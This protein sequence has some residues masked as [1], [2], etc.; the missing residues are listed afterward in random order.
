MNK[1]LNHL[2]EDWFV[3]VTL[4][5]GSGGRVGGC[6]RVDT[7]VFGE[8]ACFRQARAKRTKKEAERGTSLC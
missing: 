2:S 4:E 1:F 6:L 3:V 7:S 5:L 8:E